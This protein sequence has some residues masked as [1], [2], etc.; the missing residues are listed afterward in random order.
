[1]KQCAVPNHLALF[2]GKINHSTAGKFPVVKLARVCL[3]TAL[4]SCYPIAE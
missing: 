4:D 3:I 1:L 2:S